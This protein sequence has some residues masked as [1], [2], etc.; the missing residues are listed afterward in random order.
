MSE[1]EPNSTALLADPL[2]IECNRAGNKQVAPFPS[3]FG[4]AVDG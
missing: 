4:G 3:R 2:S 1:E